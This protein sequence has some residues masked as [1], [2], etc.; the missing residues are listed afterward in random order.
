MKSNLK[1]ITI[2]FVATTAFWCLAIV[3]FF[4]CRAS[5]DAGT[6]A[7]TQLRKLGY[8]YNYLLVEQ[9]Q[10]DRSSALVVDAIYTNLTDAAVSQVELLRTHLTTAHTMLVCV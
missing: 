3:G 8:R 10:Q 1:I 5:S 6:D 7:I 4:W 9:N 2:T